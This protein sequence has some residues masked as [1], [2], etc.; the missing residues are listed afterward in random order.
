MKKGKLF[1][2]MISLV[3][4]MSA[5]FIFSACIDLE[6]EKESK[7]EPKS[8]IVEYGDGYRFTENGWVYVHIEGE[9]YE[10]GKQHGYLVAEELKDIKR[11][12]EYLTMWNTGKEFSY[13]VENAERLFAERIDEEFIDEMK[14]IADGAREAGTEI[15]WQEI[16]AW[17]GYEELTDYWW[18]NEEAGEYGSDDNIKNEHC[19]AFMATAPY[20]EDGKIVM[21]HNSWNN[22]EFGQFSN[23]ILDIMPEKGH[24][25]FMQS[26]PGYIDS[27]ADF[28]VT[29]AG[30]MGTETTIGGY[31]LYD[32]DEDPEFFRIRK[33]MQYGDN[34]DDYV[35]IM[36]KKNNGGYANSWLL[37]DIN[38]GEIMRYELGLKYSNVE[39]KKDGYFIGFNAPIDPKIRNLETSN[40]GYA[41][42][43]RHQGAR[44]VR[45]TEL[46]E[47]Y[48]EKIDVEIGEKIM[49]DHYDVYLEKDNNPS[50]RTV[51]GHYELDDRAYM[52]QIGRPLPYQPRGAVDGKV[53]DSD[54]AESLEFS[55]RWGNSSGMA[56]DADKFLEEHIQ[57][58][59]L[60]GYL[61]DRPSMPWTLFMAGE[62]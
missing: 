33:A 61:K 39:K 15:S 62:K 1:I 8:E 46:M 38:S 12:L 17:N 32:P 25:I 27:F 36:K 52:S 37:A 21:G 30:I 20:T 53:M 29:D 7:G 45:L 3:F 24:R 51:D 31:S 55:A 10:R 11:S 16:L 23:L 13:F 5:I 4:L 2:K 60:K 18:P 48:K 43:R 57:W 35:E 22:F 41:D 6:Q 49:A 40:S 44:Q 34:L 9:A 14:G 59:Y 19:S 42:I 58:D 26:T 28:F 54:M 50:S 47:K 56:F